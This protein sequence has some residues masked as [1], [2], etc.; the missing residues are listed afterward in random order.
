LAA[1]VA[2]AGA[3]V[4]AGWWMLDKKPVLIPVPVPEW[5]MLYH[6]ALA[7]IEAGELSG[8][9][10]QLRR[11]RDINPDESASPQWAAP[12]HT[13][14]Y[15]P[16]Y[17]LGEAY[18]LQ[19]NCVEALD[20]WRESERQGVVRNTPFHL[21]L[22]AAKAEC[23]D[24]FS[25]GVER[26]EQ[27]L[28]HCRGLEELLQDAVDDPAFESIWK[29]SPELS[30]EVA[31]AIAGFHDLRQRFDVARDQGSAVDVLRLEKDTVDAKE[32][33]ED[34]LDRATELTR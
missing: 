14:P 2:A 10:G 13:G 11:A 31:D 25:V 29:Q 30:R 12:E 17:H 16:H 23:E 3:A 5:E 15:L 9:P 8:V 18:F 19:N 7:A 33:F 32:K 28:A 4:A 20:S 24:L 27:A 1:G 21:E 6:D 22:A 34:L 26:V